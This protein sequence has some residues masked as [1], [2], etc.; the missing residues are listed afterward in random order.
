MSAQSTLAY[1][2]ATTDPIVNTFYSDFEDMDNVSITGEKLIDGRSWGDDYSF[3]FVLEKQNG[4]D[5]VSLGEKTTD[6]DNQTF[7]FEDLLKNE[8]FF[9][10]G[11]YKYKVYEQLPDEEDAI[12]DMVYDETVYTIDVIVSESETDGD[13]YISDV[14]LNNESV[15]KENSKTFN[16]ELTFTNKYEP[17]V[18]DQYVDI[19]ITKKLTGDESIGL[20]GYEFILNQLVATD[21]GLEK[22]FVG[23]DT[24]TSEGE[25]SIKLKFT[26]ETIGTYSY[27]LTETAGN[28]EGMTYDNTVHEIEITVSQDPETHQ[29]IIEA[30]VDGKQ[31]SDMEEGIDVTFTNDYSPVIPTPEDAKVKISIEKNIKDISPE[32]FEFVLKGEDGKIVS[33]VKADEDGKATMGLTFA[34]TGT[35]EYTLSEVND[36]R[37]GVT[38]DETVYAIKITVTEDNDKNLKGAVYVDGAYRGDAATVA[39]T[40][41][42]AAPVPPE[43]PDDDEDTPGDESEGDKP[44]DGLDDGSKTGDTFALALNIAVMMAAAAGIVA[45]LLS[46]RRKRHQ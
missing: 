22:V 19:N 31:V 21:D 15:K 18:A 46:G 42:Y 13:L 4:T 10:A 16:I 17:E 44:S 11:T 27:E 45:V 14:L 9:E 5:W 25:A 12:T 30:E 33:N 35:Y 26:E 23:K 36:G 32:D 24:S 29:L 40:N 20:G 39:F 38:Y 8:S 1:L 37:E 34:S 6:K 28:T 3:T 7:D 43:D 41:V 2:T